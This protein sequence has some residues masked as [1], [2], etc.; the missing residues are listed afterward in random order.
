MLGR[1]LHRRMFHFQDPLRK[2]RMQ[3]TEVEG[4]KGEKEL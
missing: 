4:D 1:E 2:S 3:V